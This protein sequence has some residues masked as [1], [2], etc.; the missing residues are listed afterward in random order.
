MRPNSRYVVALGSVVLVSMAGMVTACGSS[1]GEPADV[2]QQEPGD[3]ASQGSGKD[4][5]TAI[6][7]KDSGSG[8][9]TKP[10]SGSAPDSAAGRDSGVAE[11]SGAGEDTGAGAD[12][13]GEEDS[14]AGED[15][16]AAHDSGSAA[17]SG[18][19]RDSGTAVDSGAAHDSGTVTEAG[20]GHDSGTA[21]DSGGAPDSGATTSGVH[22][23]GNQI[24]DGSKAIRLLGVDRPGTEYKCIQSGGIFDGPSDQASI[25]AMLTWNINSVRIPLNED[26]WLSLNGVAAQYAGANYQNAIAAYVTLLLN[27]G[28][29]PILDLHWTEDD[30]AAATGQQPM[31]DQNHGLAFWT[32]VATLFQSQ[33]KVIFDL[34]NEPFP[35]SN[36][37]ATS[38][39]QCWENGGTCPG[40]GYPVAGMQAMLTAVRGTGAKNL[41]VLGGLEYSNDL[42]QWLTYEPADPAG[43]LAVSWHVYSNSNYTSNHSFSADAAAVLAKVPI[44]ATEIGDGVTPPACDGKYITTVMDYL[45][46]PGNGVPPQSYLAWSW[47][48]D[49]MPSIISNYDGTA[50]CDGA[51]YKAHLLA[52]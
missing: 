16:G 10:D 13:Q 23:V 38:A 4:A 2:G 42:S 46:A 33:N 11:D 49:N 6:T 48:T 15:S 22:V 27:N 44:V 18:S 7:S 52:Q 32:S 51:T 9:T 47:S 30:G 43:N 31:P 41:V 26:C 50:T 28:I 34:F 36:M 21:V 5:G 17:D 45:D 12:G 20:T 37:D 35:D 1:S 24:Y 25:A 3:D 29:Y 19:V 39:W 14:G 40:V 8:S